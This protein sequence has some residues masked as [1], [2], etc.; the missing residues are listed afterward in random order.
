MTVNGSPKAKVLIVED[1]RGIR[2]LLS[3]ELTQRG[4]IVNTANDGEEG[5]EK[6]KQEKYDL[7]ISDIIMPRV[8]GLQALKTIKKISPD[9]EVIMITGYATV[10]NALQSM[11]D[12]AYDFIQKPFNLQELFALIDKALEKSELKALVAIYESSQAIFSTLKLEELLPLMI[13]L[14]KNVVKADEVALLLSD[15]QNQ[16]YLAAASFPLIDYSLKEFYVAL[17]NRLVS[18]GKLQKTPLV[19]ESP[20][21]KNPM[22]SG[23]K[24]SS[25]VE[26]LVA[27]PITIRNKKLGMLWV[28]R[29]KD[30]ANFSQSDL[31]NLSIFVSQISQSIANTKL[32]EQLEVKISELEDANQQ[33]NT[34]KEQLNSTQ[35]IVDGKDVSDEITNDI[36]KSL[37]A[38]LN[39]ANNFVKENKLS[40]NGREYLAKVKDDITRCQEKVK[41]FLGKIR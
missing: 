16:L 27:C 14:L 6:A 31:R 28:S 7:V 5:I 29:K 22:F 20:I 40:N 13:K 11:R 37:S 23:I 1:E 39:N 8:N 12:G 26:S 19:I 25:E 2:N 41:S 34:I 36:K 32:Y 9:T 38:I 24:Q 18:S 33:L 15:H 17:A 35:K 30:N 3:Y 21:R 10:E 4:Y